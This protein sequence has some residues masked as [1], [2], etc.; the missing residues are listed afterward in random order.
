MIEQAS[1]NKLAQW[2]GDDDDEPE[3]MEEILREIIVIPDDEEEDDADDSRS[4]ALSRRYH[5]RQGSIEIVS[6]DNM[7]DAMVTRPINYGDLRDVGSRG[8]SPVSEDG[9]EVTFL[10]YGQY[11]LE[12]PDQ[13]RDKKNGVHRLRAWGEARDRFRR[14]LPEPLITNAQP[15][16]VPGASDIIRIER[17]SHVHAM[18]VLPQ[19][20]IPSGENVARLRYAQPFEDISLRQKSLVDGGHRRQDIQ[21]QRQHQPQM[22]HTARPQGIQEFS[23]SLPRGDQRAEYVPVEDTTQGRHIYLE[24]VRPNIAESQALGS[25]HKGS[26]HQLLLPKPPLQ[27]PSKFEG[28]LQSIESSNDIPAKI[29]TDYAR[30]STTSD[31]LYPNEDVD[32]YRRAIHLRKVDRP[33]DDEPRIAKRTHLHSGTHFVQDQPS[34]PLLQRSVFIPI[35]DI[36]DASRREPLNPLPHYINEIGRTRRTVNLDAA[37]KMQQVFLMDKSGALPSYLSSSQSHSTISNRTLSSHHHRIQFSPQQAPSNSLSSRPH[38]EHIASEAVPK[39]DQYRSAQYPSYETSGPYI[40]LVPEDRHG[41]DI[42]LRDELQRG[43]AYSTR[44]SDNVHPP[45][46]KFDDEILQISRYPAT[47]EHLQ[48][49]SQSFAKSEQR[50]TYPSPQ[51]Q[52][53]VQRRALPLE[54]S[55]DERR[56][57]WEHELGGSVESPGVILIDHPSG[58]INIPSHEPLAQFKQQHFQSQRDTGSIYTRQNAAP[59]SIDR[60][61]EDRPYENTR[62]TNFVGH[63]TVSTRDEPQKI[64]HEWYYPTD[65]VTSGIEPRRLLNKYNGQELIVLD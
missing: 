17:D 58:S 24:K 22:S 60:S 21:G 61:G 55:F 16:R 8:G 40:S 28:V 50:N 33:F 47:Q 53:M 13:A 29:S 48:P 5:D 59:R 30:H 51:G 3:E 38:F 63:N 52:V 11:I 2:R 65:Q 15:T 64:V 9:Q 42:V 6:D 7:A 14:P 34:S 4:N 32:I 39:V 27:S 20:Q 43:I 57:D 26:P 54:K 37:P 36:E 46:R 1:L 45:R 41:S 25:A 12:R 49:V 23:L 56:H 19:S 35:E 18:E 44:T 10:G 62:M 31:R